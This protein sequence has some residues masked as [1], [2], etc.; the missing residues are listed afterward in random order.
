MKATYLIPIRKGSKG[1]PGKNMKLLGSKPLVAWVLDSIIASRTTDE[2]WVAT[3]DDAAERYLTNNF[4]TVHVYRRSEA[5]ATGDS[6]I[7][8]VIR[9]FIKATNQP[10][11]GMLVLAQATSPFTQPDEFRTL[12]AM[13]SADFDSYISC[14]REKKFIWSDDA[15]PL[16]YNLD[17]KPRRQDYNGLLFENGAFYASRVRDIINSGQLISGRVCIVESDNHYNIDIDTPI[18]WLIAEAIAK[19]KNKNL[20]EPI[21]N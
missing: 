18:D 12:K 16:N 11:D 8:D 13:F 1:L 7:I 3:D 21:H 14:V 5:S 4:P 19:E 9:E 2:I 15:R 17:N 20:L 6:P 10:N